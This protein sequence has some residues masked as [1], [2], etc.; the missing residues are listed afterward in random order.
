M[1]TSLIEIFQT[2][3]GDIVLTTILLFT[4]LILRN[5]IIPKVEKFI[6]RDHYKTETLKSALFSLNMIST[7]IIF[8]LILFIWGFDLEGLLALSTGL[9]AITGVALFASWSI[10]SNITAFFILLTHQSYQR[11]NFVR[12]LEQDNY[13]EGY[14]SEINLFNTKLISEKREVIIYPNNALIARPVVINPK[15]RFSVIGKTEDFKNHSDEI[16]G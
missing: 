12:V 8:T 9:I 3:T 14:I 15:D 5:F 13:I 4:Y 16:I 2:Y 7:F 1:Q 6:Q 10:L 11:G